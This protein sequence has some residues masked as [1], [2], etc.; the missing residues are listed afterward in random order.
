MTWTSNVGDWIVGITKVSVGLITLSIVWGGLFG[1][2]VPFLG[3]N[4][5]ANIAGIV[6]SL[7]A[8]GLVGLITLGI[9]V[10]LF[11]S[12]DQDDD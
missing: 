11:R 8:Q 5:I 7:G 4:T 10:W 3:A 12:Q 2:T 1:N 9:V 6:S